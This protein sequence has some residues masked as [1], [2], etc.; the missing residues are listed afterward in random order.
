MQLAAIDI[1]TNSLHMILVRV[2]ADVH[3]DA[4]DGLLDRLGERRLPGA[5]DAVEDDD[6][7]GRD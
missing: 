6:A 3:P 5:R 1:G 7:A 4:R 2:T